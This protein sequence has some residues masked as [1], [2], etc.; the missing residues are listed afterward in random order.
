MTIKNY[1]HTRL[2][3]SQPV[4]SA[5]PAVLL[6]EPHHAWA[7]VLWRCGGRAPVPASGEKSMSTECNAKKEKQNSK[8]C[9]FKLTHQLLLGW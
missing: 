9:I 4:M 8:G 6:F 2:V 5:A 7:V 3:L 1:S